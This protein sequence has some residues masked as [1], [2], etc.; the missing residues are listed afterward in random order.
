MDRIE[1]IE[2]FK[3]IENCIFEKENERLFN[4][5][6]NIQM[7]HN[8]AHGA[9]YFRLDGKIIT[10]G[11]K[12]SPQKVYYEIDSKYYEEAKHILFLQKNMRI[13]R[14]RTANFLSNLSYYCKSFQDF[15]DVLP[16]IVVKSIHDHQISSLP[17][18]R[19]VGYPFLSSPNQ[20]K[21]F[22]DGLDIVLKYILKNS[23]FQ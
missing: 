22:M 15:R 6:Y 9:I 10:N 23:V 17:R 14:Q 7:K 8:L 20:H 13:D 19:E 4:K 5:L 12:Q 18:T 3:Y 21:A 2:L 16:D 11:I 1:Y